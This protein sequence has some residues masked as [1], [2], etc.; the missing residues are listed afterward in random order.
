MHQYIDRFVEMIA[1]RGLAE[2][3]LKAYMSYI[4][5]FLTYI[6]TFLAKTPEDVTWDEKRKY[7]LYLK[8]SRNLSDRTINGHISLIRF[9][10]EYVLHQQWDKYQLP[11][12]KFDTYLPTVPSQKEAKHFINTLPNL[13]HKAIVATVYSAGLRV[14]EA[15]LL[16]YSDVSREDMRIYIAPSKNRADRYSILSKNA[17]DI[18]TQYWHQYGKPREW[19]FPSTQKVGRPIVSN[20]INSI[21]NEHINRLGWSQKINCHSFRHSFGTHLYENGVDLLTIQRLMGHKL[22]SSTTIYV[23]LASLKN[24]IVKSPFD[25][26]GGVHE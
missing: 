4:K 2:N 19:L 24:S 26:N 21:V 10:T 12:R 9:F 25:F 3:T 14:S 7:A 23:H 16:K 13:K 20:T 11:F 8:Q 18:L 17:L 15:R 6:E 5:E 1:I 22:L